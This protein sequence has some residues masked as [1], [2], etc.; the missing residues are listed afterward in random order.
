METT[1]HHRAREALRM[2][3]EQND[4]DDNEKRKPPP[5][6]PFPP[7]PNPC[8]NGRPSSLRGLLWLVGLVYQAVGALVCTIVLARAW[9]GTFW[10]DD[11]CAVVDG[12][13]LRGDCRQPAS[14]SLRPIPYPVQAPPFNR[15][16]TYD[17]KRRSFETLKARL[18]PLAAR[19]KYARDKYDAALAAW[20]AANQSGTDPRL[21]RGSTFR[22][23]EELQKARAAEAA[24]REA[25]A[26][27]WREANS[28]GDDARGSRGGNSSG[29]VREPR[30]WAPPA[31]EVAVPPE[32]W[33]WA[34]AVGN[35][36]RPSM[37]S[38]RRPASR[39]SRGSSAQGRPTEIGQRR[40]PRAPHRPRAAA[41]A[42]A[43]RVGWRTSAWG[44]AARADRPVVGGWPLPDMGAGHLF[45]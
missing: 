36:H 34:R 18:R 16:A 2:E 11:R 40:T 9:S 14:R 43:L 1:F 37:D 30:R 27:I 22:T 35:P 21:G 20:H 5:F 19:D 41:A 25:V 8:A 28:S 15:S 38:A 12:H 39:P 45:L 23:R 3:E 31:A 26:Q 4:D 33:G 42:H 17:E 13:L 6:P 29:A 32:G 24:L 10:L 44:A 7:P